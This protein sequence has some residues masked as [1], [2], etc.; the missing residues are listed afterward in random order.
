MLIPDLIPRSAEDIR[1]KALFT[2]L[3]Y[4]MKYILD[5]SPILGIEKGRQL[6]LTW[7]SGYKVVRRIFKARRKED[8]YWISRDEFT[9]KLFLQDVLYW[10][11]QLNEFRNHKKEFKQDIVDFKGVQAMRIVFD[12]GS[13]IHVMSSSV[14]AIAGKRGHVYIDEAALHKDFKQLFDIAKPAT[15][16][17]YTIT[18][19]STHR[20]KQ[21]YFYKLIEKIKKGEVPGAKAMSI[22]LINALNEGYLHRLN[23]KSRLLNG[24]IYASNTEFFEEEKAQAS[25]EEMFLQENM[26]IP[27][28][29]DATQAVKEDDLARIMFPQAEIFGGPQPGKKYFAGIDVGRNRDLTVIWICEDVSTGKQPMFIARH[30]QVMSKVDFS[31]QERKIAEL[32]KKWKPRHCM[33]DGTNTGAMLAENLEKRFSFV[34]KTI[35]TATTRPRYISDLVSFIRRDPVCL[36]VPNSNEVWADFLSVE[37]YINKYGKEDFYIPAHNSSDGHGDR[38]MALTLCLQAF[39]SKRSLARYTL[40][41]EKKEKSEPKKRF[42]RKPSIKQRFKM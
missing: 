16:W 26:C 14:D 11:H 40:Q 39:M 9:A 10:I 19:F 18:F 13:A 24:R 31:T 28:D 32:L 36:K 38:F 8:H 37:R 5:E 41:T 22:T 12:D 30:M 20:S 33:I 2:L 1:D 21:N 42:E 25:S 27:A 34:E 35:F 4:Q 23:D 15:R 6:G 29:A 17:G 3:P 7:A